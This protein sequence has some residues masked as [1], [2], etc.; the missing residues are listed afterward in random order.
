V[1]SL[2]HPQKLP[3]LVRLSL[4]ADFLQVHQFRQNRVLEDVMTS[5]DARETK[6]ECLH[7]V[8]QS[9]KRMF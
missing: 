4:S 7:K 5:A 3:D 9:L 6:A 8:A 2:D 1:I